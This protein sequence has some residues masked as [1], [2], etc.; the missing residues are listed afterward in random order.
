MLTYNWKTKGL[1]MA[2]KNKN[3]PS[4]FFSKILTQERFYKHF[5]G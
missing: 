2:K 4:S 1:Q 3:K 5:K